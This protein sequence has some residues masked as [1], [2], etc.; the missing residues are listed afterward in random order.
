MITLQRPKLS[1]CISATGFR[2][3]LVSFIVYVLRWL[4]TWG[5]ASKGQGAG[6]FMGDIKSLVPPSLLASVFSSVDEGIGPDG[7][8]PPL[9]QPSVYVRLTAP[10][11]LCQVKNTC[12]AK[13]AEP[14]C[15]SGQ[16]E[17]WLLHTGCL[18]GASVIARGNWLK[19]IA[20]QCRREA[21]Y[22]WAATAGPALRAQGASGWAAGL[23]DT[24]EDG[25]RPRRGH[26]G[27][28]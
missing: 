28:V 27:K 1:V 19:E 12:F 21:A 20:R 8:E 14:G 16:R 6:E 5:G 22:L 25:A 26:C 2:C 10:R 3:L 13:R 7:I 4:S 9:I 15:G 11:W 18:H 17:E 24:Q 23:P